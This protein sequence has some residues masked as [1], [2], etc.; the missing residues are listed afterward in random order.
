MTEQKHRPAWADLV[1][2]VSANPAQIVWPTDTWG[3]TSD[4]RKALMR[5]AGSVQGVPE[6]HELFVATLMVGLAHIKARRDRDVGNR[7][8]R[9]AEIKQAAVARRPLERFST[10]NTN[11]EA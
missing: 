8:K 7:E 11:K 3:I 1:E 6:K 9:V 5:A 10:Y 4:L 2:N